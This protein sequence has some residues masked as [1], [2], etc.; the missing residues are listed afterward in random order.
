MTEIAQIAHQNTDDV[1]LK[2]PSSVLDKDTEEKFRARRWSFTLNNYTEEEIAHITHQNDCK[3]CIGMEEGEEG[4][5]HLQG[6][7]E[8]PN[9]KAFKTMKKRIG[10]RAH[11]APAIKSRQANLNYCRKDGCMLIDDFP[12]VKKY[13]GD[14]LPKKEDLFEWQKIILNIISEKPDD[15]VIYWFYEPIGSSG[16]S[17]FGKYLA[18]HHKNVCLTTATKSADILTAVSE[19]YNTYILDFPRTLGGDYC[20]FTAIEQL[21]NGFITDSKLK[22]QS[23]ILMFDP[24]HIII[25]SNYPPELKKLSIDRWRVY[26]IY[27]N[28]WEH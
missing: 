18:F 10:E 6:Y 26:N 9:A 20:P 23:R 19:E 2:T 24:P 16:K 3:W 25:F 4:T 21:K 1:I 14:D 7:V 27:H 28:R 22:K 12:I 17:K 11:I 15:R 8:I 5:K 13:T